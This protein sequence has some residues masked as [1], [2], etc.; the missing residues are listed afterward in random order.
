MDV[1]VEDWMGPLASVPCLVL[2]KVRLSLGQTDIVPTIQ[3]F[4][5]SESSQ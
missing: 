4:P 2:D 5:C 1:E 3:L